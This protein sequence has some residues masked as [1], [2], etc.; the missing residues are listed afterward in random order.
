[1]EFDLFANMEVRPEISSEEEYLSAIN[2][3]NEPTFTDVRDISVRYY[4]SFA[5]DI[6]AKY[7]AELDKGKSIIP[8][9][10]HCAAYLHAY[11]IKHNKRL[12]KLYK[13]LPEGLFN[14]DVDLIDWGCGQG[15]ATMILCDCLQDKKASIKTV[16]LID[17]SRIALEQ[18]AIY[19]KK[20]LPDAEINSINSDFKAIAKENFGHCTCKIHMHLFANI[21]D[22]PDVNL[23]SLTSLLTSIHSC[24]D[25][26]LCM[27]PAYQGDVHRCGAECQHVCRLDRFAQML[28]GEL[29]ATY[30]DCPTPNGMQFRIIKT[31]QVGANK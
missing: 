26:F 16:T 31:K 13:Q 10:E 14:E 20:F 24:I 29:I 23:E 2:E 12:T 28:N 4:T 22:V 18:A 27:N 7:Y 9:L 30:C 5:P 8:T 15:V 3:L 21:I 19:V 11:G 17:P 25:Y 1:M 6:Q